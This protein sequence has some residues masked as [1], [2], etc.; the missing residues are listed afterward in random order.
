[1]IR[2]GL[3]LVLVVLLIGCSEFD[4]ASDRA[5]RE[6][7]VRS[8]TPASHVVESGDTLYQIAWAYG[9]DFRDVARWNDIDSPY[10]IYVGQRLSLRPGGPDR[11]ARAD[12]GGMSGSGGSRG[13]STAIRS[14][15]PS[16][17]VAWQ[18]PVEG[19]V[20][21]RF[22]ANAL[23]KQGITIAAEPG[24]TVRAAGD[25]EVV[26]SGNGLRG[27]GNLVIVKHNERFLTAYGY[28]RTV[29]VSEGDRV[30]G[31]DAIA[32]M[33]SAGNHPGELH[34]EVREQG[35][36]VNPTDYLP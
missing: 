12:G 33:G 25:G 15:A 7:S 14:S 32:R 28:N 8:G 17:P 19:Q 2:R 11:Q 27:Y 23:G 3:G 4:Y 13:G 10:V 5:L 9:L 18:W 34:F 1:M 36:P 35:S 26:Y 21:R 24:T 6:A 31:G 16:G 29:L 30:S 22:N 20:V